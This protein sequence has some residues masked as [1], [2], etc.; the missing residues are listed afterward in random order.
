MKVTARIA[1]V[2][3]ALAALLVTTVADAHPHRRYK[4]KRTWNP[5]AQC[6]SSVEGLASS[7]GILGLGTAR[8][9][10]AA[11]Y[12]WETKAANAYGPSYGNLSMARNV[13]WDCKKNALVLAKCVVVATPCE[14]RISG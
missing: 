5:I 3:A 12:D 7:T 9:R 8:A 14:A 1:V 11:R 2:G 4:K 10:E 13:Q 6:Q